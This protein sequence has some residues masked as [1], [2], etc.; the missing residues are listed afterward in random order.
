MNIAFVNATRKWGGVKTWYLQFADLLAQRGNR[1]FSYAR[2]PEFV[3]LVRE[4]T[5]H[6][7]PVHFGADLNPVTIAFFVREF[8]RHGIDV[9]ITNIGKDLS[10]AGV[11]A[12]L[13]KIPVVQRV[14]LPEDI[15]LRLKTRLLHEW[16]RP[17]FL[18]PCRYIAEGFIRSLPYIHADSVHV[19]LNGKKATETPLIPHA[20]RR[21][22]ATQQLQPD[23]GHEVLL[24]ALAQIDDI[25]FEFHVWGTG[26]SEEGLK[27][28]STELGLSDRVFWHGFS[29]DI[30]ET[31]RTGDIF[32]LASLREGLPN[33]QLEAMA[34]GLLPLV[35]NVG[36]VEEVIPDSLQNWVLPY[37][38][39]AEAFAERIRAA[40]S[41]P[42][43][44]ILQLREEARQACRQN[45][46]IDRQAEELERWFA[47][48]K[49][50]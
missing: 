13:L 3:E 49:E 22:I 32:L 37:E 28:L 48:C 43:D 15:P 42:D 36:G 23:K 5:G 26:R 38:A 21:L 39:D 25:P 30:M 12:R 9:V 24:R 40:L 10:T 44:R 27:R 50:K 35:R 29:F 8:R 4:R 17:R 45:F 2:Q 7:E 16:I 1:V 47:V 34:A 6:C 46:D 18:C 14:G 41:L 33:T 20:P 31:L 11:A 19:I